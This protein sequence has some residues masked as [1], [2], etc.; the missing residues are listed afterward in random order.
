MV[1]ANKNLKGNS[2]KWMNYQ[3]TLSPTTCNRCEK[4]HGKIVSVDDW[5]AK[6]TVALHI[7]C[8]CILVYMR[9]VS[10]GQ[11]TYSGENGADYHLY[12]YGVLPSYYITKEEADSF[13][14]DPLLGNLNIVVPDKMIGGNIYKNK[15]DKLPSATNRIWYEADIN[16]VEGYRG[17]SRILYSNDGLIFV[18]YDHYET[19]YEIIA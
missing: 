16:Y 5:K 12:Y 7:Y 8:G 13:G 3:S 17:Q 4:R 1:S 11:G 6:K 10:A 2:T 14:W 9:T 15:N 18:T 19:F